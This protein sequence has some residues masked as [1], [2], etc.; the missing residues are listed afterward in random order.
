[1]LRARG[2]WPRVIGIA[3][4]VWLLQF[5]GHAVAEPPIEN[6]APPNGANIESAPNA[7]ASVPVEFTCAPYSD[8]TTV[9]QQQFVKF[10]TSPEL[11]P[12]GTL[13]QAFTIHVDY[14]VEPVDAQQTRC[15]A[16]LPQAPPGQTFYWQVIR[17]EATFVPGPVW[18]FN[19]AFPSKLS[20]KKVKVYVA[21]GLTKRARRA[22]RCP[23]KATVGAFFRST[24]DTHYTIC[25][26][27][28]S[29]KTLCATNQ[30]ATGGT[31]YVNKV[32]SRRPGKYRV[33]WF[34]DG[35]RITRYFWRRP[36]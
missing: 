11:G 17:V 30:A 31:L 3:G 1:M 15:R 4:A 24:V 7:P 19:M 22:K 5:A 27:F 16:V 23:H 10:A 9:S 29:H 14:Q 25:V 33:T 36:S 34:V 35:R 2:I 26:R 8:F 28:P 13:A 6:L 32:A 20:R 18:G 12:D 21:C